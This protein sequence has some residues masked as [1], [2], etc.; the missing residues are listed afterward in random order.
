MYTQ[1]DKVFVRSNAEF[2]MRKH[3]SDILYK[4]FLIV[5]IVTNCRT[6]AS[7]KRNSLRRRETKMPLVSHQDSSSKVIAA[8]QQ[9]QI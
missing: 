8:A 7:S 6:D 1:R 2:V 9:P 5:D 4:T 3:K